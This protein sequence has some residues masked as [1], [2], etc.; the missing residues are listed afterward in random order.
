[1]T[2]DPGPLRKARACRPCNCR[3]CGDCPLCD[4]AFSLT[5]ATVYPKLQTIMLNVHICF[6]CYYRKL[7]GAASVLKPAGFQ[8]QPR[9]QPPPVWSKPARKRVIQCPSRNEQFCTGSS[10]G[11]IWTAART[12]CAEDA[13][14]WA[15]RRSR[16]KRG[17]FKTF[18]QVQDQGLSGGFEHRNT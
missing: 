16:D 8:A 13:T 18:K 1:M 14:R 9:V 4:L 11:T 6:S 15:R 7:P 12:G 2:S 17:G 5:W 3:L 10:R